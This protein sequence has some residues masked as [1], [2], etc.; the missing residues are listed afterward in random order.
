MDK[1]KAILNL[2]AGNDIRPGA[3]NHDRICHRPEIDIAHDLNIL[4]WPW[5]D[6]SFDVIIARAVFEH[7]HINLLESVGECWRILRPGGQLY[8]KLPH[9]QHDHTYMDPTHYWAFAL[10]TPTI[11]DPET[12][13]GKK[14]CFYTDRK[15]KIVKGPAFNGA[16]SSVLVTMEVRK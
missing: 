6:A 4:P 9:W 1:L 11:F 15:W 7:L 5:E 12:S 2:G 13:Y 3:I 14:Y 16:R 10:N 8:M